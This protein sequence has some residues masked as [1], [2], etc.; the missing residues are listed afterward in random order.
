MWYKK[1]FRR[2]L[3]DMHVEDWN[4]EFLSDFSADKYLSA[5]K[6]AQ[7]QSA[8]IYLQSHV[9][10]CY[11]PT[12]SGHMHKGLTGRE[13]EI[14]RLIDLCHAAGISV[15]GYYSLIY[16]NWARN[17]HPQWA[18]CGAKALT[19]QAR[20]VTEDM[21]F[22]DAQDSRY[23]LCCPNNPEYRAFVSE[24]ISEIAALIKVDGMFFDM[25]FW[26][27][28]CYCEY[29]RARWERETGGAMPVAPPE[30]SM[31]QLEL[32]S[33]MRDWMAEF[34]AWVTSQTK[35][36]MPGVTVTHNMAYS[37]LPY[38]GKAS[39]MVYKFCDYIGG[40]LY[41]GILNESFV[42]KFYYS[43]TQNQPFEYM[44]SR[45]EPGLGKHTVT[46]SP[47]KMAAQVMLAAAH[48]GATMFIDAIDPK[49]TFDERVYSLFSE[50]YSTEAQYEKYYGG[51]LITDIGVYYSLRS[52]PL[53]GGDEGSNYF[54]ALNMIKGFIEN[55]ISA[56]ITGEFDDLFKYKIIFAPALTCQDR[57]DN[58]RL[59]NYVRRGGVLY[60]D[61]VGC[62]ELV[63]ELLGARVVGVTEESVTYM[64]P[65]KPNGNTNNFDNLFEYF[66]PEYPI[67]FDSPA[68]LIEWDEDDT[69]ESND[70][71]Q[72]EY[73]RGTLTLP[74]TKQNEER[75]ASIHSNPPGIY[76]QKAALVMKPYGSGKV[77]W[78]AQPFGRSPSYIYK[79]ILCNMARESLPAN[80][81]T[82]QSDAPA[83]AEVVG[84]QG[85]G[86]I[87]L[88]MVNLNEN[89][90]AEPVRGFFVSVRTDH[91]P[92]KVLL[93]P[94]EK[95]IEF[96]FTDGRTVFQVREFKIFD[97][98]RIIL[99]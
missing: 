85:N 22:T 34:A 86:F 25:T 99:S 35:K 65:A 90:C 56:G 79:L 18:L 1:A 50:V 58:D 49:G 30:G 51:K 15:V 84:F 46:K 96:S 26:P 4:P 98:Y 12:K 64:S 63:E 47:D 20:A 75:F 62:R 17:T 45:C 78:S 72:R 27:E 95:E 57:H 36:M 59:L 5:L 11:Y 92:K 37:A 42:C 67:H 33:V 31:E 52:K 43:Y 3:M 88:S 55:N 13:Y 9:G 29:C 97:M 44:I 24:Q 69:A 89:D 21:A 28:A 91:I 38:G 14:K 77:I 94:D 10:Y 68:G 70:S 39:E 61:G 93:L 54:C 76:T 2:H 82:I 16:N 19:G 81:F 41:Q 87:N 48:Q 32:T 7:V 53:S 83:R 71:F 40:D 66:T 60:L 23:G 8:M 6:T 73:I 80:A 74:Y